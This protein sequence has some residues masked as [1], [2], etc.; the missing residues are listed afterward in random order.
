MNLNK[1]KIFIGIL[2]AIIVGVGSL[3]LNNKAKLNMPNENI[4]CT[5]DAKM[6][7]DGSYVGRTAPNCEFAKCSNL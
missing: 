2:V 6:C 3:Y 7:P 1:S 5:M 4:A